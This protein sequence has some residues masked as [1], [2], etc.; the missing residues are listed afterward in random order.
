[1]IFFLILPYL[2][3]SIWLVAG[4]ST[5]SHPLAI[6]SVIS[7]DNAAVAG[8]AGDGSATEAADGLGEGA[9]LHCGVCL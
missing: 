3:C 8:G 7:P 9:V 6:P 2:S 4:G 1:M 5:L